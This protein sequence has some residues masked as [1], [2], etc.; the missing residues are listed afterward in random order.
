MIIMFLCLLSLTVA[1]A[2]YEH[3]DGKMIVSLP[4]AKIK[5]YN[6]T[7]TGIQVY[8]ELYS[9]DALFEKEEYFV[10]KEKIYVVHKKMCAESCDCQKI[11]RKTYEHSK[12][13]DIYKGVSIAKFMVSYDVCRDNFEVRE[14]DSGVFEVEI[15]YFHDIVHRMFKGRPYALVLYLVFLAF[16]AF[17]SLRLFLGLLLRYFD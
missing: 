5:E 9:C 6:L 10:P 3:R 4:D 11:E 13:L 2:C 8:F 1:N 17:F 14:D 7:E 15:L 12:M 16:V